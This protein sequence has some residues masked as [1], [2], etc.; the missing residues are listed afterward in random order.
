[1]TDSAIVSSDQSNAAA[2]VAL[3]QSKFPRTGKR[4]V[5]QQFPRNLYDML[6]VESKS[7]ETDS[8]YPKIISWSESGRA[9][10]IHD[11][12]EFTLSVLPLFFRTKKFSSFQRNLNLVSY[13]S[14]ISS[15]RQLLSLSCPCFLCITVGLNFHLT[16]ASLLLTVW[17]HQGQTRTRYGHVCSPLLCQGLA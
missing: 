9:F 8:E 3:D 15:D 12:A 13:H 1:M 14:S 2:A 17:L 7:I 10:R 16:S 4:G 6:H 5:P 11:V